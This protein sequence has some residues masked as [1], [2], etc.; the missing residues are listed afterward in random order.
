MKSKQSQ[1]KN[2][3][4]NHYKSSFS[5]KDLYLY[6][7]WFFAQIKF[8][9]SKVD[10]FPDRRVLEIG[11][12]FGG[13]YNMLEKKQKENYIGIELDEEAVSFANAHFNTK[14]FLNVSLEDFNKEDLNDYIFAFEVLEHL[15]NPIESVEKIHSLLKKDGIFIGTSPFPFKKNILA[16]NTHN[17][18]LH[19]ENWRRL[20]RN[21][22]FEEVNCF[23]M[24]FIPFIFRIN[25]EINIRIPFYVPF[26]YFISTALIIAKK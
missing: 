18:V 8:I 3:F 25:K 11:S 6:E 2:Y 13:F 7:K 19:P 14:N 1:Y 10:I 23:P 4:K 16:D 5:L 20:F 9:Q 12:G 26:S 15:D 17:F 24:S 21:R 22:G